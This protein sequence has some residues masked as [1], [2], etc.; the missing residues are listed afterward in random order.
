MKYPNG[1]E[2]MPGHGLCQL[3]LAEIEFRSHLGDPGTGI[4]AA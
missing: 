2:P 1:D 4:H 3:P